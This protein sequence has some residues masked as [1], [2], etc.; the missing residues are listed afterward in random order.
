[1]LK[2]DEGI[3]TDISMAQIQG[4]QRLDMHIGDIFVLTVA[5]NADIEML[6]KSFNRILSKVARERNVAFIIRREGEMSFELI[7]VEEYIRKLEWSPETTEQT[8]NLVAGNLR[9]FYTWLM[10]QGSK[11]DVQLVIN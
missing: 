5:K 8:K 10:E 11:S 1:M 3:L 7:D 6:R 4:V 2:D 9:G